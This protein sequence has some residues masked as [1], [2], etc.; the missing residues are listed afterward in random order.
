MFIEIISIITAIVGVIMSL[1]YF[2]QAYRIW[3][4]KHSRDISVLMFAIFIFGTSMYTVYGILTKNWVVAIG[5][6][7]GVL[8]TITV[9]VL[10]L[11]YRYRP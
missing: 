11:K 7:V 4:R 6:A 5:F 10:T 2:L 3:K 9:M 8:G 1:S